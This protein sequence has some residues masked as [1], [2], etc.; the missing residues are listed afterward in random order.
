MHDYYGDENVLNTLTLKTEGTKST[1]QVCARGFGI[2]I[3]DAQY[4]ADLI[5]F[6]R[7]A[8]WSLKD[9]FNGNEEKGRLPQTEF[10]NEVAKYPGLK[11]TMLKIEGLI[12]GRSI[13]ASAAYVF[14]NGYLV[15]NSRMRAPNG[16]WI[17]AFNMADSDYMGGLKIDCLTI[18]NLDKL[19]KAIDLL[20][21]DKIIKG[22]G[23]IKKDYDAYL[24]PDVLDFNN[25][26]M[27][28]L[29]D[30]NKITDAFQFDTQMGKQVIIKTQPRSMMQ[31]ATANSLMR[32]MAQDG[33]TESP[34][35]TYK[36]YKENINLWY[37]E[38]K[39]YNLN[40]HEIEIL[41]KHLGKL[42][43]VADTQESIM[44]LSMDSKIAGFDVVL[45]NK[46]RKAVA[47][48]KAK[49]IDEIHHKFYTYGAN[50]GTRKEMLDYVWNVEIKRQ[51]GYSFSLNHVTPYTCICIQCMNLVER[52]GPIY[53]N[54]A[55]LIVNSGSTDETDDTNADYTKIAK[56]MGNMQK[57]G[58]AISLPDINRSHYGF[59]PDAKNNKI[60]YGLKPIQGV[61]S[62]IANIIVNK[63]PFKS[64]KDFYEKMQEFKS[65]AKENK[66]GDASMIS[67]IK[68]GCFDELENRPRTEIMKDFIY[69][70][71]SPI[72]SLKMGNIE[73]LNKM[74]L[75]T[76]AQKKFELRLFR[77]KKYLFQK[78]FFVRQ[79]GKSVSTAFYKLDRK[80]AEPYFYENFESEMNEGKDYEYTE[81]G[82]IAVKRGAIE[83]VFDKLTENF[84]DEVLTN[85]EFLD[86]INQDRFN[87][88][89]QEKVPGTISQWEMDSLCVYYSGHEL[90]DV[91][92]EVYNIVNFDTLNPQPEISDHYIYRGQEKPRYKL[93][94]IA[95]TVLGRDKNKHIVT[96]LTLD[97]VVDVKFYKG[98]FTFYDK[99][100]AE[101][102][103]DG[104]KKVLEK[105]W[106]ARGTK[107]LITGFRR[108]EQFVPKKYNDSIYRHSVQLIKNIDENGMLELQSERVGQED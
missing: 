51:L 75:L 48:K 86:K 62:K 95:G 106:F 89:W 29:L 82:F 16:T 23:S 54:C 59:Y 64:A 13:H 27:W 72:T 92:K 15:Q 17:T 85:Q 90:K 103:D 105:S 57:Q 21:E 68:A 56:A 107:L 69:Q 98:Q 35:D 32:L 61:G 104:T 97:G 71:S 34:M 12:S 84:K 60:L 70:I 73:D 100:I 88:L 9:C 47:K 36:R 37:D 25:Y 7:G 46:L 18:Q 4:M 96:L 26:E 42:Y 55:C 28:N 8:N 67:L 77:F 101:M 66:F 93:S 14:D 33:A 87:T 78:Q 53:W 24:H 108:D 38:M 81:D 40:D 5:P 6:E 94:R 102:Q 80:F 76:E 99:Q 58:I 41:K 2:P 79:A 30:N 52:Y 83:R 44:M 19:H 11:E 22:Y 39:H 50:I 31:L 10:I 43:G 1:V 65:E 74:G 45:A 91:N 49:L 20:I 3:E 63:R